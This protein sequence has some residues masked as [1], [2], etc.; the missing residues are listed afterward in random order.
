MWWAVAWLSTFSASVVNA[1]VFPQFSSNTKTAPDWC[2]QS[3]AG[4]YCARFYAFTFRCNL[5]LSA[6]MAINSL[7]VGFPLNSLM[8]LPKK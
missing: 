8:E 2:V 7:F 1:C 6:I 3:G 5:I 4:A